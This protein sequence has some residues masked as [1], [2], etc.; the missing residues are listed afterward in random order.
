MYDREDVELAL[1]A[2]EEGMTPREA[3]EL[4]G[5]SRWTVCR[6]SRGSAPHPRASRPAGGARIPKRERRDRGKAGDGPMAR[7]DRDREMERL[8]EERDVLRAVLDD[9]K[10]AGSSRRSISNR[11]KVELGERLRAERGFSL[12]AITTC[13]RISK[14]SYE[15]HRARL[16]DV[17]PRDFFGDEVERIFRE[18]GRSARGYRFVH[19]VLARRLAS[20]VSE[21]VVRDIMRERGLR[22]VYLRRRRRYSSYAGELDE[23][24]PNLL[25]RGDGTHDFSAARPN[26]RWVADVTEFRLPGDPRKVYLSPVVDL[27]DSRPVAWS[28]GTSPNATL[29]DSSLEAA[30]AALAPGE[31]P[32]VHT[33]RGCHYRW[34]GWKRICAEH[35]LTRSMSRKGRSPDNAAAEGFFGRLKNEFFHGRDWSGVGAEEFMTRLDAW[36][37]HYRSGRLRAFREDGRWVYD[38]IDGRRE[39]LGLAT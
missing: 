32:T 6:W 31:A 39:R 37:E 36:M 27:Y 8:R 21:K 35:G 3:A 22:P 20:P 30:C 24:P 13:L 12:R 10:E 5:A 28:I 2:L 9:L 19:A 29:V 15:Y 17:D 33:D 4:V 25:L 14:S 11:R 38:T 34:P 1:Y 23:A 16:A 18:D 7:P 26:E